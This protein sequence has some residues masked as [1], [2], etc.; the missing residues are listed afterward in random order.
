MRR[1]DTATEMMDSGRNFDTV[2]SELRVASTDTMKRGR[3]P[4][5]CGSVSCGAGCHTTPIR[6][7]CA[8][9][10]LQR[11]HGA[12]CRHTAAEKLRTKPVAC[13]FWTHWE[14]TPRGLVLNFPTGR[15]VESGKTDMLEHNGS[16]RTG[17]RI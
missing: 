3:V 9:G 12:L 6:P 10:M 16:V 13:Y 17:A 15:V 1:I 5:R 11:V 14:R 8:S 4:P 7:C 2:L